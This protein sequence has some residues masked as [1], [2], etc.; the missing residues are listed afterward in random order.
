MIFKWKEEFSEKIVL[1]GIDL[2]DDV[3][4]VDRSIDYLS[5]C[6]SEGKNDYWVH[7][8][9]TDDFT[10]ESME[11]DC[12]KEK[13]HHMTALLHAN[14]F[15]F[16]KSIEY[17]FLIDN[18]DKDK[19]I[20]FLKDEVV[21]NDDCQDEFNDKFRID[22]LKDDY[23][24]LDEKLFFIFDYYDWPSII[25]DFVKNDV[26][27]LYE[28]GEYDETFYLVSLIFKKVIDRHTYDDYTDLNECYNAL[29]DLI[30]KL[31]KTRPDLIRKFIEDCKNHNYLIIYPPFRKLY[32]KFYKK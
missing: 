28:K 22:I 19:L 9:L 29:V 26:A 4:Y 31:S 25:T 32:R 7:I 13:C 14:D 3:S 2:E 21:Y 5:G 1:D 23:V 18:L 17:E 20:E 27:E 11:C 30:R 8:Y 10:I 15:K 6:V 12:K 24:P 16:S